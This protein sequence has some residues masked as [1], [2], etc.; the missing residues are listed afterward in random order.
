MP[1]Y[2]PDHTDLGIGHALVT[3]RADEVAAVADIMMASEPWAKYGYERRTIEDFLVGTVEAGMARV[4]TPTDGP[5]EVVGVATVQPGFLGGRY[6]E[7]LALRDDRRGRGLGRRVIEAV[8]YE[9]PVHMRDLFVLV[10][11]SNQKAISFYRHLG[12]RD[13]GDLPG[14]IRLGKVE[15]LIWLRFR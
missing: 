4:V 13:V 7:L 12:F 9:M 5:R 3:M 8:C 6:L 11:E 10:A 1:S 2:F 15:R 14:L